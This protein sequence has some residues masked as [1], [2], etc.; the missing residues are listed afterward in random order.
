MCVI[1]IRHL[2]GALAQPAAIANPIGHRDAQYSLTVLSPGEDDVTDVHQAILE[3]WADRV[4]GR[5]LNFSFDRLTGDEI[6]EAFAPA[7]YERLR[8]LKTRY[9]GDGIPQPNH[10]I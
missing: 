5:S 8:A 10:V 2:G 6:R 3:P 4:V 1:G 7:D 9:D